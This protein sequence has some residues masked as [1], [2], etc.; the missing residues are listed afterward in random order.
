MLVQM[1]HHWKIRRLLYCVSLTFLILRSANAQI[2]INE[3]VQDNRTNGNSNVADA[4]EF[5]ELYNAGSTITN[6][7]NWYVSLVS[8][9][10]GSQV[11]S[12]PI[13]SGT[14]LA[15]GDY[16]VIGNSN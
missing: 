3:L 11:L 5:L 9:D 12:I 15:P 14:M 1:T 10:S 13:P 6:I 16:Y 7:G 8:L 2:V 4:G